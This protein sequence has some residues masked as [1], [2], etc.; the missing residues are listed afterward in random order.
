MDE[1]DSSGRFGSIG[2]C[3]LPLVTA[4]SFINTISEIKS[5]FVL[6]LGD[7]SDHDVINQ[8]ATTHLRALKDF[9]KLL[10][11][12]YKGPVYAVLGNHEGLPCDTFNVTPASNHSWITKESLKVWE[13][14]FTEDMKKTFEE[15]GCYST[16]HE[17]TNL[18]IIAL[19]P[20]VQLGSNVLLWD[21]QTDP[22]GTVIHK[23]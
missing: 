22:L 2:Q 1:S 9:S 13:P 8:N 23:H 18:R 5:D 11:K 12:N 15:I 14:W 19:N 21:N 3:D 20:F 4:E 16:L 10:Q 7:S 17:D 6:F